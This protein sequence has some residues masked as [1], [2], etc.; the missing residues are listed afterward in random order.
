M[1]CQVAGEYKRIISSE[2]LSRSGAKSMK[3]SFLGAGQVGGQAAFL[4][5]SSGL[6][7]I[8]LFDVK[9]G[10][11]AGKALDIGQSLSLLPESVCV[12]GGDDWEM[13]AG[14]DVL[15]VTAGLARKPGM[16]R[17][18]LLSVNAAIVCDVVEKS[19]RYSP[20]AIV[21]IVT[22]PINTMTYLGYKVSGLPAERVM[23]MAG[24]LDNARLRYF[25]AREMAVP[26][27]EVESWVVGD[28]GDCM[29]PLI[30]RIT[31]SGKALRE[32]ASADQVDTVCQRT[33]NAGTEILG[34]LQEGSAYFAPGFA[35]G[36]MLKSISGCQIG[37]TALTCSVMLRGQY[38]VEGLFAGVPVEL[39]GNG[40]ERIIELEMDDDER[41][42][43]EAAISAIRERNSL[44]EQ[45]LRKV[46]M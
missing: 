8:V 45:L 11:A 12:K 46:G 10:I 24:I 17:Q 7:E 39:G 44:A 27:P 26:L 28:H 30:S 15:V 35:I 18:D 20:E 42:Q 37:G 41:F 23:G 40:V 9:P 34:L 33:R 13:T 5:A 4:A 31:V 43:F 19:L 32:V 3:I 6:G 22:N 21:I 29:V 2:A 25:V 1:K 14:S 16:S 36:H 38:G